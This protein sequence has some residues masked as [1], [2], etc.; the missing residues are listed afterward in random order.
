MAKS[1]R[2][3]VKRAY[4]SKKRT[5]GVYHALEAARLQRL[6]AKLCGLAA[7]PLDAADAEDPAA[8]GEAPPSP[9]AGAGAAEDM[10]MPG[11]SWF[12]SFGLLDPADVSPALLAARFGAGFDPAAAADEA[13]GIAAFSA[14][15]H[16]T[17][18]PPARALRHRRFAASSNS[19]H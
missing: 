5:E 13:Y 11:W 4:R 6:S 7:V 14:P 17:A 3:K 16:E 12:A 10:V 15:V 1:T 8:D 2:S 18:D 19:R 9:G